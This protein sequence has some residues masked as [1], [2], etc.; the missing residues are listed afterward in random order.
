MICASRAEGFVERVGWAGGA[1]SARGGVARCGA[2]TGVTAAFLAAPVF[3]VR[4]S[5]RAAGCF[6]AGLAFGAGAAFL[7]AT[8]GV[9]AGAFLAGTGRAGDLAATLAGAFLAGALAAG[10]AA[11]FFAGALAAGFA[12]AFFA[13]TADFVRTAGLVVLA[14][15]FG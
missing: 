14:P 6:A 15:T 4:G 9:L 1:A 3:A 12:A 11:A 10:F 8:E 13:G 2:W 5:L 7:A